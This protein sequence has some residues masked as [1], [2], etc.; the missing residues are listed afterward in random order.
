MDNASYT[1]L[2]RQGGLLREMQAIA[3]NIANISTTGFR[4]EGLLFSEHIIA[5]D[6]GGPSLSMA[7]ANVRTTNTTQGALTQ[8]AGT[9]DFAIEGAGYFQIETPDG[10]QL[11]RA[12]AFTPN[13]EGE[14][15]TVDGNPLL[16]IGGSR[17]FIPPSAK[18]LT[19]AS[20]G[21]LSADGVPLSQVG[22]FQPNDAADLARQNGVRFSIEGDLVSVENPR[23]LQGFLENSN[24]NSI[25]AIARMI[26]VQ[27]AYELG[28]QFLEKEDGRIRAV[29]QTLGQ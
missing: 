20:D 12:G 1:T 14:L 17:I 9:Y 6:D 18:N 16:D 3:N 8:T 28:Q 29:L 23:I 10:N 24:V 4:K 15:V 13:G 21:T 27:R 5:M 19:L 25:D 22:L 26:E 7:N 11:T 2:N